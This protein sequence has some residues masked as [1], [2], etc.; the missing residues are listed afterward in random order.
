MNSSSFNSIS[1]LNDYKRTLNLS[2]DSVLIQ[3]LHTIHSNL[4]QRE[5]NIPEKSFYQRK[6]T[7]D[8][9][10]TT[11][12]RKSLFQN[13][14]ILQKLNADNGISLKTF[15]EYM[16]IQELI[17]ERLFKY[18]NKSKSNAINR[19]EFANGL[20]N[21]YYGDISDL[22]KLTFF[23]CDFNDDG[24]IYKYDMRLLLVYIPSSSE[25]TQKIKIKQINKIMNAFFEEKFPNQARD[26]EPEIDLDSYTQYIKEY[27]ERANSNN[28]DEELLNDFNNNAPFFYFI[29]ILS[30]LFL[31]CPFTIKN[32]NYFSPPNKTVKLVLKKRDKSESITSL[33][34]TTIR[35]GDSIEGGKET[36]G[37]MTNFNEKNKYKI[38]A[39]SKIGKKN[40]FKPKRSSSQKIIIQNRNRDNKLNKR[41][42]SIKENIK[43][44]EF[45]VAKEKE[46][47]T[48]EV[49]YTKIKKE[50]NMFKKKIKS[51][52]IFASPYQRNVFQELS[53]SPLINS[54][55]N[56]NSTNE[57]SFSHINKNNHIV[58]KSLKLNVRAKLPSI[59]NEKKAPLSVG[60]HLKKED[61]DFKGPSEFVLCDRTES[62]E[63][64]KNLEIVKGDQKSDL[65]AAYCFKVT[66]ETNNLLNPKIINKF[67][68]VLSGKEI[69]FFKNE[70]KTDFQ[71][72]WYIYKTHITMGTESINNTKY[73]TLN[74]NFFHS[75]SMN[76]LYFTKE[77]ECQ[78]FAKKVKKAINNLSFED[79]YELGE[80]IGQGNFA[81]A[82]KCKNKNSNKLYA[83]KIID[84]TVLKPKDLELIHQERSYLNLIKHPNIIGLKDYFEDKKFMY[85][86]TEYC[87]GG[88]LITFLEKNPKISEKT[89]AKIV[90]KIAEGIRYLNIFGIIHRDIKPENI[91]FSEEN[92]IKSLKIIDLGVCKTLTYGQ[93]A[94]E[95]IGTNGYI[96]PEIYLHEE[97]SFKTDIW[98]LGIILYLLITQGILPFDHEDMDNKVIGK[99][100]IYL[101]QE[102]PDEYFGKC[103]KSLMNLLDKMLEKN[104]ERRI[105]INSLLKDN[106]FNIIKKQG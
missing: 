49:K 88:D 90:R 89:A 51:H 84:K 33:L 106:W 48:E 102:Y 25:I 24:K 41:N 11:A 8:G 14:S 58:P 73:F 86:V 4:L 92:E 32:I 61:K 56:K 96:S 10:N 13:R 62:E 44:R 22:I 9:N 93:M 5:G 101:Q 66:E 103:S 76:K 60:F 67:Y 53:Q 21:L 50:I 55:F 15:L 19:T 1:E 7:S 99:K 45:I 105:D 87:S 16:N 104:M 95:P 27:D 97:Y 46:K 65:I 59:Q 70:T 68:A 79:F 29:S 23:L 91:L 20:K 12:L 37:L 38:D 75:K 63:S 18:F 52:Q 83:V 64:Q 35:K 54:V 6:L 34:K 40:L 28:N 80:N 74:I 39:L 31:N 17:G 3:Y 47:E 77:N 100:V 43:E 69:L 72:L 81:K 36:I 26:K 57:E 94:S 71:D 78:S 98:S 30:Y 85:L 82:C 42:N 2:S